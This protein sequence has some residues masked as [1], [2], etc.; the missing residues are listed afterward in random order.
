[1]M[2]RGLIRL[3]AAMPAAAAASATGAGIFLFDG[4]SIAAGQ[5]ATPGHG[6][7]DQVVALLGWRGRVRNSARSGRQM[8]ECLMLYERNVA[9]HA[10]GE[11]GPKLLLIHAGDNDIRAGASGATAFAAYA[12]YVARA[13]AQGWLVIA[14]TKLAR[15]TFP[16]EKRAGLAFFNEQVLANTAGAEAVIDYAALPAFARIANRTN[17]DV[18]TADRVHPSD[19]GYAILAAATAPVAVRL[20]RERFPGYPA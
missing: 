8:A 1:M 20:L 15:P 16:I 11:E 17:P 5:G 12:E 7:S 4:D 2:R 19:G 18:F 10:M 13:R 3:L 6:L 9:P 14:S